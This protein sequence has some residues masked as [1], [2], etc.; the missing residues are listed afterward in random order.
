MSFTA[1]DAGFPTHRP[2][3]ALFLARRAVPGCGSAQTHGYGSARTF[4][5]WQRYCT[6]I[7]RG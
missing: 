3:S 4:P 7:T 1:R 2:K 6:V 5:W